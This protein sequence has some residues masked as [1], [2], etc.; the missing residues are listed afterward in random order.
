MRALMANMGQGKATTSGKKWK[1]LFHLGKPLM[2]RPPNRIIHQK[3]FYTRPS[4]KDKAWG[5]RGQGVQR[6]CEL[7]TVV[8]TCT[9]VGSCLLPS[10]NSSYV[11]LESL[12]RS[13]LLKILST[14]YCRKWRCYCGGHWEGATKGIRTF[15]GVSSSIGSLTIDPVIL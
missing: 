2:T 14:R 10:T 9:I 8:L 7:R 11:S 1:R 5:A 12:S 3:I 13:I 15:S 4:Y 6:L